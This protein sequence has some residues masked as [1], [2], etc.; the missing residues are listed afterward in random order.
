MTRKRDQVL[1]R[2][3]ENNPPHAVIETAVRIGTEIAI[4]LTTVV[5]NEIESGTKIEEEETGMTE[6]TAIET[7]IE[8]AGGTAIE[9]ETLNLTVDLR[10]T[11]IAMVHQSERVFQMGLR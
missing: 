3:T 1:A 7:G 11:L 5:T 2:V 4:D 8:K 6:R 9:T 10:R